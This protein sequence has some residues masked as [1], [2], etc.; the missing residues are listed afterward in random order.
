MSDKTGGSA[1]PVIIPAN[2]G[3]GPY[4]ECGMT[5]LDYFAA[6][7]MAAMVSD[8]E[9]TTPEDKIAKYSYGY[10]RAMLK[11]RKKVGAA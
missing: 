3:C 7:A 2:G 11:E 4:S 10:A 1:F 5:K 9:S 8:S 6:K